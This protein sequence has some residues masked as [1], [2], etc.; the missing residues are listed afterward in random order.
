MKFVHRIGV[1]ASKAQ[2]K[3]L[4]ML[5]LNIPA[6]ISLPGGGDPLVAFDVDEDHRH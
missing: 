1:R 5:G 4:E 3:E 2:R 6:G